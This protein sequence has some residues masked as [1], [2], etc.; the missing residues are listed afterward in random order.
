MIF[1]WQKQ[2]S[3]SMSLDSRSVK[4]FLSHGAEGARKAQ[5][6]CHSCWLECQFEHGQNISC[7]LYNY[8]YIIIKYK[9][10]K[11][12]K[13]HVYAGIYWSKPGS[14]NTPQ[15]QDE[16][17]GFGPGQ[18]GGRTPGKLGGNVPVK[19]AKMRGEKEQQTSRNVASKGTTWHHHK[20]FIIICFQV[21]MRPALLQD[22]R[23]IPGF[24]YRS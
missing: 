24:H 5:L 14:I 18:A 11:V 15:K 17:R 4:L 1:Q 13:C 12:S 20:L 16:N 3:S 10:S 19:L 8:I 9:P 21:G 6:Q 7:L 2:L 23:C 22:T